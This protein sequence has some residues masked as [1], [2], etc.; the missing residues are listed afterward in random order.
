M[1]RT[2]PIVLSLAGVCF[3]QGTPA[4]VSPDD[5]RTDFTEVFQRLLD[6]GHLRIPGDPLGSG[7]RITPI[8]ENGSITSL[9]LDSPGVW[10]QLLLQVS[11]NYF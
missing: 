2:L 6:T 5:G 8:L 4:Q 7:A 11:D 9:R 1:K 3:A 10:R